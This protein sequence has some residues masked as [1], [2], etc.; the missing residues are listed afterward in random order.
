MPYVVQTD[1]IQEYNQVYDTGLGTWRAAKIT[2]PGDTYI[3]LMDGTYIYAWSI[4]DLPDA[5]NQRT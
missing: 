4:L 1:V 5:C 3:K 2:I